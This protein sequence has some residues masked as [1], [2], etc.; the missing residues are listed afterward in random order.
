MAATV[1]IHRLTGP[2]PTVTN[3]TAGSSRYS[4][5]DEPVPGSSDPVPIPSVGTNHSFWVT[6][7]LNIVVS[8]VGTINNLKWFTS[9]VNPWTG[10]TLE[11]STADAYWQA[12]GSQGATGNILNTTNH[13]GL[14]STPTSDNAFSYDAGSPLS[15]AGSIANPATGYVG[16]YVV[17]QFT[18]TTSAVPGVLAGETI[19]YQWDET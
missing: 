16:D 17:A 12:T 6:T 9:G 11:A 15:V 10:A 14:A 4:A 2:G 5:S 19:T 8:P 7:R 13:P 18:L 1:Q 3:I